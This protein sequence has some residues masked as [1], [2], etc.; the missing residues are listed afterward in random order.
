MS[1]NPNGLDRRRELS[2]LPWRQG[3]VQTMPGY[4]ALRCAPAAFQAQAAEAAQCLALAEIKPGG[5]PFVVY[6]YDSAAECA[7]AVAAHNAAASVVT[8]GEGQP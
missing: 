5:F 6:E 2:H 7:A 4:P 1:R 3:S 8:V